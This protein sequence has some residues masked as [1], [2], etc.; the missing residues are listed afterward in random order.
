M[1]LLL[2][3]PGKDHIRGTQ[4]K[5]MQILT[6]Y[7][8]SWL[9]HDT[10]NKCECRLLYQYAFVESNLVEVKNIQCCHTILILARNLNQ[11]LPLINWQL[12]VSQSHMPPFL[13]DFTSQFL[14]SVSS[15]LFYDPN[16][17]GCIPVWN[18]SA[19]CEC[20]PSFAS[21]CCH[22]FEREWEEKAWETIRRERERRDNTL[23]VSTTRLPYLIGA[24][25]TW[26]SPIWRTISV[27]HHGGVSQTLTFCCV[28]S[29]EVDRPHLTTA[30]CRSYIY[31][32]DIK[33][34]H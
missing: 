27:F 13:S 17:D 2:Y 20:G 28:S 25:Q 23:R 33:K 11:L 9:K 29:W 30:S 8:A 24:K 4:G 6:V 16:S 32:N 22:F 10:G 34:K 12:M 18:D 5:H 3:T 7:C 1:I 21:Y 19:G 26:L 31:N 14:L 15:W